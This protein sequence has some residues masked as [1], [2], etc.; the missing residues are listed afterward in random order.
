MAVSSDE[1]AIDKQQQQPLVEADQPE[2][3]DDDDARVKR[4][5]IFGAIVEGLVE[6]AVV[7]SMVNGY[8]I[9]IFK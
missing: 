9:N 3:Y 7:G 4:Q 6:G 2:D 1:T 5:N 8:G